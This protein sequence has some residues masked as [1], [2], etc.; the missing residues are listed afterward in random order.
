M[1][2]IIHKLE[3]KFGKYAINNLSLILVL[4]QAVGNVI[5]AIDPSLLNY[6]SLNP[7]AILHGQI[8]R[9]VTWVI[10]PMSVGGNIFL[11]LIMLYVFYSFGSN[12]ERA[13]GVFRYN[14]YLFSGMLFTAL[15]AFFMLCYMYIFQFEMVATAELAQLAFGILGMYFSTFYVYMSIFLAM[16]IF[17]PDMTIMLMFILPIKMKFLAII[18][19]FIL[20][21][22][23]LQGNVYSRIVII[24]SLL[25][26]M[27]LFLSSRNVKHLAPK[28]VVRRKSFQHELKKAKAV[29]TVHK[30]GRHKCAICGVTEADEPER[31]F[32]YC[33]KCDGHYQYCD[34][35]IYTHAHV[36]DGKVV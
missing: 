29:S 20:L 17:I 19:A 9:L 10:I 21:L 27:L 3:K 7:Y 2:N 16:A 4:L 33:S 36:K 14:L 31:E 1:N 28:Q 35:H 23:L 18:Y 6:I 15:G 5:N 8:W 11:T 13:M 32:R 22:S 25:N 24:A 12:L 34:R 26:V 30:S